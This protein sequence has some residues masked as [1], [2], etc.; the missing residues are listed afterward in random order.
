MKNE[1]QFVTA[2]GVIKS[3]KAGKTVRFISPDGQWDFTSEKVEPKAPE[4]RVEF[5]FDEQ[6]PEDI[7]KHIWDNYE[8]F[9]A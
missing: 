6:I 4:E 7:Q 5:W 9:L 2:W 1:R 8:D 3:L